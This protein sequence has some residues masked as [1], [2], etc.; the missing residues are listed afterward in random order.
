V[1]TKQWFVAGSLN[2]TALRRYATH[3]SVVLLILLA[4][5]LDRLPVPAASAVSFLSRRGDGEPSP[6]ELVATFPAPPSASF[7]A[8]TKAAV[9]RT[10]IPERTRTSSLT[11]KVQGGDTLL[12]IAQKF[13]ISGETVIWANGQEDAP[14]VL[15]IGQELVILPVSG[16]YHTVKKGDTVKN[17]AARYKVDPEVITSYEGNQLQ[18]PY[19]LTVGD[20]LIV[21]GGQKP[22]IQRQVVPMVQAPAPPGASAG[23][24]IFG[25]PTGGTISQKFWGGHPAIDIAGSIKAP[26]YAADSGYVASAGWSNVG[27]GNMI[28]IDHRNGFQ[29]MYAHLDSFLVKAGQSVTKGQKIALMGCTGRCT[30]PHLHFEVHKGGVARNPLGVLP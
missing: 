28:L 16:V 20:K 10:T 26:V 5:S 19:D 15:R 6:P 12:G 7:L 24:G 18:P 2:V 4:F 21:P 1:A 13:H 17:I 3:A 11:Y 8:L 30:G 23:S 9:L 27:Y 25:W 22:I 29:T 14:D